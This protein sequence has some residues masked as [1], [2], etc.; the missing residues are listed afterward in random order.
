MN[1]ILRWAWR[2]GVYPKILKYVKATPGDWDDA[3]LI[4]LSELI[5]NVLS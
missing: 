3:L 2:V 4:K 1:G 5:E